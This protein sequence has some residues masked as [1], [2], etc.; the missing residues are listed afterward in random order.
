ME[1]RREFKTSID[2][3]EDIV[4]PPMASACINYDLVEE[5][6]IVAEPIAEPKPRPNKPNLIE[7]KW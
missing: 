5:E 7:R 2:E 4:E 1:N 6:P 3:S